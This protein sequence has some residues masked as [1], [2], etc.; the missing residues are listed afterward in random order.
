[1]FTDLGFQ[2]WRTT[3]VLEAAGEEEQLGPVCWQTTGEVCWQTV[4]WGGVL[5]E[6]G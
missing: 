4:V 1:M 6:Q 3:L 5:A 2:K